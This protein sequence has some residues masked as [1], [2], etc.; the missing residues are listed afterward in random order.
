MLK[1]NELVVTESDAASVRTLR[2]GGIDYLNSLPLLFGLDREGSGIELTYHVPSRLA[3]MLDAGELDVALI[4]I[5]AYADRPDY[6]IVPGIGISSYGS[7]RSIRLY[8]RDTLAKAKRVGLDTCSRTSALLTRLLF[9]DLWENEPEFVDVDPD[10]LHAVLSGDDRSGLD[11]DGAL[12]IGDAALRHGIYDGWRNVDLG[13]EWTRWTGLPFVYAFWACRPDAL[14][15]GVAKVLVETLGRARDEGVQRIDDIVHGGVLSKG[16]TGLPEGFA[17][18][19][20]IDY[21]NRVIHYDL[22]EQKRA[23]M[24][25]YLERLRAAGLL[26]IDGEAMRFLKVD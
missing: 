9:R 24:A 4:P 25:L 11:L 20:A 14:E 16:I 8:F 12:L 3:S 7:V 23:A 10:T 19:D 26:D 5:V 22:G 1:P 13:T 6:A 21:L 17:A 15:E 2:V 18:S